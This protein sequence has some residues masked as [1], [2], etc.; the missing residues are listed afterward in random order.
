MQFM[1][2]NG[3]AEGDLFAWHDGV[4]YL[5]SA[6]ALA[7]NT[8]YI[9]MMRS[10]N[11]QMWLS[12]NGGAEDMVGNAFHAAQEEYAVGAHWSGANPFIGH[13]GAAIYYR[14]ILSDGDRV[15]VRDYLNEKYEIY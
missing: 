5:N 1:V 9:L 11:T 13:V 2:N 8:K 14:S 15:L 10:N 6:V 3:V 12:V 4:I 7:D